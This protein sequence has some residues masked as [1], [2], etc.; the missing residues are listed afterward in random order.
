MAN[1]KHSIKISGMHC[2]SCAQTIE[3]KLKSLKG[4]KK[5]NVNFATESAN[6]EYDPKIIHDIDIEK[7]VEKT[8]YKVIKAAGNELNLKIIGMDNPHCLNT[9]ENAL[10]LVKG[11]TYKKLSINERA[12]IGYDPSLTNIEEIK[13]IIKKAGYEP[14][15]ESGIDRE[16]E[17]R[18][19]EIKHLKNLFLLGLI[20]SIPIFIFSFPELFK[21][22]LEALPVNIILLILTT[23]VQFYIGSGFYKGMISALR[24]KTFNMDSLIAIGTSVAYFYSVVNFMIYYVTNN[25]V[26]GLMGEKIPDFYL[27]LA[28][29]LI[30]FVILEKF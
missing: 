19:K 5:V 14:I 26:L 22:N 28:P 8:G 18:E 11:I 25:S 16:K 23:P 7:A 6:I 13:K 24:M 29:F 20:L 15:E 3:K 30:T 9:I 21:L 10:N 1:N 4:V 17:A 12:A 27:K 2:A